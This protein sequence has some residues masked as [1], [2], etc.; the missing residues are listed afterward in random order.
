[1]YCYQINVGSDV[2]FV[3]ANI[4]QAKDMFANGVIFTSDQ[5]IELENWC[6]IMYNSFTSEKWKDDM[7]KKKDF[8]TVKNDQLLRVFTC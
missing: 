2:S 5:M 3:F 6:V 8:H 4:L 1:M 7:Q